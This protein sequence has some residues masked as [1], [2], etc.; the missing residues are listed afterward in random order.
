MQTNVWNAS[1]LNTVNLNTNYLN[2]IGTSWS[3][4]ITTHTWKVG[5]NTD[6]NIYNVTA[7]NTYKNEIT[8]PAEST[9]YDAKVG[10]MYVSDYGYAVEPSTWTT[11]LY[12]Y[13][14][15]SIT[16]KSWMYMGHDEWTLARHSEYFY[17]AFFVGGGGSVSNGILVD[18][19]YAVRPVLY[20]ASE[21][22]YAGGSGTISSPI[23]IS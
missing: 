19:T 3:N 12:N 18:G 8:T 22:A 7:P 17:V 5:G 10:L 4:K 20:L 16:N 13:D 1:K 21:T 9:T 14:S 15:I 6:A 23:L 11:T 2:N